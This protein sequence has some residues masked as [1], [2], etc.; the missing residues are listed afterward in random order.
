LG[1]DAVG[2]VSPRAQRLPGITFHCACGADQGVG[3]VQA[4]LAMGWAWLESG[5]FSCPLCKG[6]THKALEFGSGWTEPPPGGLT[7]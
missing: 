4:V 6:D 5:E 1:D 3:T 2:T 7:L